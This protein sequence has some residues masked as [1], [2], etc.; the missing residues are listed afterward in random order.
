[1]TYKFTASA[2][3]VLE[4]ANDLAEEMG[5][6]YIGTEHLLFGLIKEGSGVASKIFE[7]ANIEAEDVLEKID[8]LIG[9]EN[10]G[11]ERRK[12]CYPLCKSG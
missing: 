7:N 2:E 8:E 12:Q 5:H 11:S 6:S 1:M 9:S 4:I 3:N 10:N